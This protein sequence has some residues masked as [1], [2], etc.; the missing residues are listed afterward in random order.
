LLG[1]AKKEALAYNLDNRQVK[2]QKEERVFN[3]KIN[4]A[5][6]PETIN[7]VADNGYATAVQ[8]KIQ[9]MVTNGKGIVIDLLP[10]QGKPVLNALKVIQTSF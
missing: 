6:Y 9:V 7:L 10:L 2:E 8:K 3:L 5:M 1:G 4:E